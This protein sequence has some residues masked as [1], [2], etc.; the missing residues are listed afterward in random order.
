MVV[1]TNEKLSD[2]QTNAI[3]EILGRFNLIEKLIYIYFIF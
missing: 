2:E 1:P 3:L